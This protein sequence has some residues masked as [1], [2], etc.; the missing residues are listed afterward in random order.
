MKSPMA[1]NWYTVKTLSL[2]IILTD[3]TIMFTCIWP[4]AWY[5]KYKLAQFIDTS[6]V[7]FHIFASQ[8]KR[9]KSNEGWKDSPWCNRSVVACQYPSL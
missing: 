1:D 6:L 2:I 3:D 7:I 5:N 4:F 8:S 9:K